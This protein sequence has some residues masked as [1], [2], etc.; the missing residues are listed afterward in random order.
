MIV[1]QTVSIHY[2]LFII[3]FICFMECCGHLPPYSHP[4]S[5]IHAHS[6]P[7]SFVNHSCIGCFLS[8]KSSFRPRVFVCLP[9]LPTT[10]GLLFYLFL[11][12]CFI[13]SYLLNLLIF[14]FFLSLLNLLISYVHFSLALLNF[15]LLTYFY[16]SFYLCIFLSS[17]S[18]YHTIFFLLFFSISSLL[19][20]LFTFLFN[21]PLCF[22]FF[23]SS[24]LI[25]P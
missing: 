4:L 5:F 20:K 16:L 21:F 3:P 11:L 2:F 7:S 9:C 12:T 19:F 14:P 17:L 25:F 24:Y 15:L 6:S 22:G 23:S 13:N 18:L 10:R 8:I 1:N